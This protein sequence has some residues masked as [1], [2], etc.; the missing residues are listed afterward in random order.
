MKILSY[1]AMNLYKEC[2]QRFKFRYVDGIKEGPKSYFS[3]GQSVHTALEFLY[4]SQLVP[5]SLDEMLKYYEGNW[6]KGGYKTPQE[7]NLNFL[8][9]KKI[10]RSFY[11]KHI[12]D[13]APAM[14][15]E[16]DFRVQIDG[17]QL[18]GKVD[19][20]DKLPSG[21]IHV[22]DYKTG[23]IFDSSR[24]LQDTQL[25]LYQVA[26]Q[27]SFGLPVH[28]LTLYH[29]P[30]LTPMTSPP[31]KENQVLELRRD[32]IA[33]K[34]DIDKELF[35]PKPVDWK[36]NRCDYKKI[37]PAWSVDKS[38][39]M[40]TE[41]TIEKRKVA[42]NGQHKLSPLTSKLDTLITKV[43]D[44]SQALQEFKKALNE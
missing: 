3:F 31:H 25:T 39:A 28:R 6:V 36:C 42:T 27:E 23:K 19:R 15:T 21:G 2:P 13:W 11:E 43:D 41:E 9:G 40:T 44:L 5:P 33:V 26:C 29:L 17:V 18:R 1:S 12:T 37:C 14:A 8:E 35:D 20:I 7:E 38:P 10:L 34:T 4:R 24:A 22:I 30:S 32:I 16:Y